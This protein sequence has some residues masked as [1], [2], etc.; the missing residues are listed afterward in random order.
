MTFSINDPPDSFLNQFKTLGT[1]PN[2][3]YFCY[4]GMKKPEYMYYIQ[5]SRDIVLSI[6][7][8]TG[9]MAEHTPQGNGTAIYDLKYASIKHIEINVNYH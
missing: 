9:N 3:S 1:I 5:V 6:N 8:K 7:L 4:M 2:G